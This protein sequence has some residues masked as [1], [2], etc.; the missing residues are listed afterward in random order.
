MRRLIQRFY[1]LIETLFMRSAGYQLLLVALVIACLSLAGG[2]L[3]HLTNP[4][5]YQ[6]TY[7]AIWWAFLRLTDPGYL[8]E[9]RG[10]MPRLVSTVLSITGSVVFLGALVAIMTTWLDRLLAFLASGRSSIFERD[11]ILVI[12]WNDRVHALV[13][14]LV[15]ASRR[16]LDK[17][18]RPAIAILC[19][20]FD[21]SMHRELHQKLDPTVR[22]HCRLLI[23]SGNPLEAESLDRVDFQH[24]RS[25]ILISGTQGEKS[26]AQLSD[27]SIAKVLMSLKARAPHLQRPPNVVAEVSIPT[28]KLLLESI[29]WSEQ[30]EAIVGEE[31]LGRLFCQAVR[32][33]GLSEV[34][35][36][37]LT[38][39][40]GDSLLLLEA[41]PHA[42]QPL[43]DLVGRL[44][45]G[46]PLGYLP[47]D[48]RQAD[49][50][51]L[52]L[53]H[54]VVADDL[55]VVL[56]GAGE[57]SVVDHESDPALPS[58]PDLWPPAPVPPQVRKVL[59]VGWSP[60]LLHF[61][62]E[63]TNFGSSEIFELT[64]IWDQDAPRERQRLQRLAEEARNLKLEFVVATLA[65]EAEVARFG[66]ERFDSVVL[67]ADQ[68]RDPLL[69]DAET[70]L[71]YVL[72]DRHF[73]KHDSKVWF[74][75][76]LNDEDNLAL[77]SGR[78]V[79]VVLSAEIVSHLLAQVAIH[80]CLAWI[81]EELFTKGGSELRL[82]EL[83]RLGEAGQT[84]F[85]SC[86]KACVA[87]G[88]VA[89]GFRQE[90][91]VVLNPSPAEPLRATDTLIVVELE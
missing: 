56:S 18:A 66:P 31:I 90:D 64:L 2:V 79:D 46:I 38:D 44:P 43:R 54:V 20:P 35:R 62:T 80:R 74:L 70:V 51:L 84:T 21:P 73:R 45:E 9:D 17:N 41:A 87:R 68:R 71:R 22:R 63:T 75:V 88:A 77:L 19:D 50:R 15:S 82:R 6:N 10:L 60:T 27:M 36:R 28:N 25:V 58:L 13:E 5:A 57:Q 16:F 86:Q 85:G 24:A 32:Y 14:E 81:Y 47:K 91:R 34:T 1:Y 23:R 30:T 42:G 3:V 55:L 29:G 40:F 76:E 78:H 53:E 49:L 26:Q 59:C 37:L 89:V 52:D 48:G 61:L 72:L 8:G 67:M 83:L 11:H 7:E 65:D 69:A 33:P 4:T 12:G 39:S